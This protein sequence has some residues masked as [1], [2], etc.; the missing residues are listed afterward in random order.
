MFFLSSKS[1]RLAVKC[2]T[3][4]EKVAEFATRGCMKANGHTYQAQKAADNGKLE[5]KHK[6]LCSLLSISKNFNVG[7]MESTLYQYRPFSRFSC[8]GVEPD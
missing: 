3:Y 2:Q 7:K 8:S 5:N 4:K 1:A 6:V